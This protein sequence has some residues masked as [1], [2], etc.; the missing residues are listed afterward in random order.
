VREGG[1]VGWCVGGKGRKR[2]RKERKKKRKKDTEEK[3]RGALTFT[4]GC[5][6]RVLFFNP[7]SLLSS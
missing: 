3:K 6:S 1:S 2:G 4:E 5:L 7:L